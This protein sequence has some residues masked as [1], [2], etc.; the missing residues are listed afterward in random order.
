[1]YVH[2][3]IW[4]GCKICIVSVSR[5]R[6]PETLLPLDRHIRVTLNNLKALKNVYKDYKHRDK[7]STLG[8]AKFI[9][10]LSSRGPPSEISQD[11]VDFTRFQDSNQDLKYFKSLEYC[12]IALHFAVN[13]EAFWGFKIRQIS[14]KIRDL[15][16][17]CDKRMRCRWICD[18]GQNLDLLK[19]HSL[20]P[21]TQ[22][23]PFRMIYLW[24]QS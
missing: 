19:F 5:G 2:V 9:Y 14:L 23:A 1:M 6:I 22:F 24:L 13:T 4:T 8:Q 16:R 17:G 7:H 18:C 11:L 10:G 12:K 15:T 20:W 3:Y 21:V